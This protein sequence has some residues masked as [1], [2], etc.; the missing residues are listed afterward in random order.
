MSAK[1][2]WARYRLG[3]MP[4]DEKEQRTLEAM[5]R[6]EP[7]IYAGRI[8]VEDLLGE[9]DLLR[10]HGNGYVPGD[11]KSGAGEEGA[12]LQSPACA[13]RRHLKPPRIVCGEACL[14]WDIHGEEVPY[15]FT[16][17]RGSKMR[18]TLWESI[19]KR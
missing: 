14:W 19:R 1:S 11:I 6:G 12:S 16:A 10:K 8:S 4:S 3:S 13:L 7:L 5:R 17:A 2:E 18:E 9:P 15:D